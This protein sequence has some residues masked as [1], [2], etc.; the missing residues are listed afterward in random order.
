M[1]GLNQLPGTLAHRSIPIAFKPPGPGDVH[2]DFDDDD[3][4]DDRDR[5][6]PSA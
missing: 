3:A 5:L 4:A 2:E 6:H 1:A